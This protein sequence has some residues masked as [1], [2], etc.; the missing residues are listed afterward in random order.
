[1]K[2]YPS[3]CNVYREGRV[4]DAINEIDKYKINMESYKRFMDDHS[5]F[6]IRMKMEENINSLM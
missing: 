3:L 2:K 4:L 5:D 6:I 1:M